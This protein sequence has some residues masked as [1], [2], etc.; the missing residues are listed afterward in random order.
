MQTAA[1]KIGEAIYGNKGAA[2]DDAEGPDAEA[3]KEN[4]QDAEFEEKKEE[5]ET[6]EKHEK[7]AQ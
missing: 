2:G 1:L 3:D 4:I 6:A 5:E 7:K